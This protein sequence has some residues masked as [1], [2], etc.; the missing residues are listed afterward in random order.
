MSHGLRQEDLDFLDRAPVRQ[1]RSAVVDMSPDRVF[2]E[3]AEHPERWPQWLPVARDC[4]YKDDPPYGVGSRRQLSLR[5][6]IVAT[7]TVLAWDED[8]RLAYC[9]DEVNAPGVRA[10]MED[11]TLEPADKGRTRLQWVL[12]GDCDRAVGMLFASGR[13]ALDRIFNQ[14]ARRMS[15]L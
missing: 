3:V 10:F 7:E 12:A 1:S 2:E 5:G 6:G 11:W 9:V 15:T 4:H 8:K 13:P 14:A